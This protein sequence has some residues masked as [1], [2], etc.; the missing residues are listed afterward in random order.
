MYTMVEVPSEFWHLLPTVSDLWGIAPVSKS[1]I[2]SLA[3]KSL[4]PGLINSNDAAPD[5][6][7]LSGWDASRRS[8]ESTARLAAG[9]SCTSSSPAS[10]P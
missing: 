9:S 2:V 8:L 7:T 10:R 6:R 3:K 5:A 4:V 1:A